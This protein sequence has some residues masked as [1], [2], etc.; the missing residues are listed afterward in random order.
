MKRFSPLVKVVLLDRRLSD[1]KLLVCVVCLICCFLRA[2]KHIVESIMA[3]KKVKI[4]KIKYVYLPESPGVY[5]VF[6]LRD[7]GSIVSVVG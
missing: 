5:D 4:N 1:G 6:F 7:L 2:V 3:K